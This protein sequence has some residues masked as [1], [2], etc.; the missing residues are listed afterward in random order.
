MI[1]LET[2][3]PG[4]PEREIEAHPRLPD[5]DLLWDLDTGVFI[6]FAFLL[7]IS[8]TIKISIQIQIPIPESRS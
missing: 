2:I 8:I 5:S 1:H 7:C 6:A 4:G 3:H